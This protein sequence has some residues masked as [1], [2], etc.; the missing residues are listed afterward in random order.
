MVLERRRPRASR[1]SAPPRQSPQPAQS[2]SPM[3][4]TP[5]ASWLASHGLELVGV[6]TTI[7]GIW[8]TTKRLLICWPI[9]LL[10]DFLYLVIFFHSGLFSDALLQIFFVVFTIYGWLHWWRGVRVDGEVR[11]EPLSMRACIVALVVG[12]VGSLLLGHVMIW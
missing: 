6:V 12:A 10:A 5:I 7:I 8:L 11:V 1:R 3:I 9:T 2:H 4:W